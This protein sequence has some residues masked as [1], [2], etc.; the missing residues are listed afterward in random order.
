MNRDFRI[1]T[2]KHKKSF[3][4][5]FKFLNVEE[6][7][8]KESIE[9]ALYIL[10]IRYMSDIRKSQ[11]YENPIEFAETSMGE[12]LTLE[13]HLGTPVG[14][15]EIKQILYETLEIP[16][17]YMRVRTKQDPVNKNEEAYYDNEKFIELYGL[18]Y[19]EKV[20]FK[21]ELF[22]YLEDEL[23]SYDKVQKNKAVYGANSLDNI[24]KQFKSHN[25]D[26]EYNKKR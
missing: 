22:K 7:G 11:L 26:I 8:L 24:I 13:V 3:E 1:H 25:R 6:K 19:D 12:V 23:P 16:F 5:I 9:K 20:R 21:S 10:D 17:R 18:E 15:E 4:F 2:K 14:V